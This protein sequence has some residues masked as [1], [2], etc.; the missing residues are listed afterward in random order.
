MPEREL[1]SLDIS[2]DPPGTQHQVFSDQDKCLPPMNGPALDTIVAD[3]VEAIVHRVREEM[4][5]TAPDR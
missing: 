3:R 5:K 4:G 1:P 2:L